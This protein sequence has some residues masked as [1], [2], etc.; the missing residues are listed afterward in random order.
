MIKSEEDHLEIEKEKGTPWPLLGTV[1]LCE[2]PVI[3]TTV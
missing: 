1:E 2:V 3:E